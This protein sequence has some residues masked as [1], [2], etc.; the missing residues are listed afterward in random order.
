MS[1]WARRLLAGVLGLVA[2]V[3]CAG[4][5]AT[6]Q[7]AAPAA[8]GDFAGL[9]DVDGRKIYL[10][11]RGSGSPTVVLQSGFGN[12]ADVWSL[13]TDGTPAVAPAVAEFTRVCAYDRPGSTRVL[14]DDG[15]LSDQPRPA[16][17]DPAPMPRTAADVTRELHTLLTTAG[18][19]GPY[20][21]VGHSLGG[22]FVRHYAS[23]YPNDVAGLVVVDGTAVSLRSLVTPKQWDIFASTLASSPLPGYDAGEAY[24]I[25]ASMDQIEAAPPLPMVT[26]V[27][28]IAEG[29]DPPPNPAP[30]GYPVDTVLAVSRFHLEAQSRDAA[31]IPG[32]RATVVPGTTHDIHVQRPGVVVD[33]VRSVMSP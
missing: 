1:G 28:L 12:G 3:S 2:V 23:T 17:S 20:V 26:V 6:A 30:P 31:G 9:V 27:F 24:D 16:R 32:A 13:S 5:A 29:T 14:A 11:C 18:A 19:P 22:P 8:K 7:P 15:S 25:S 10:E 33:A 4:F 21:L